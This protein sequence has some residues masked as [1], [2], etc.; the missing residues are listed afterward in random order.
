MGV[1][2]RDHDFDHPRREYCAEIAGRTLTNPQQA[3]MEHPL[4]ALVTLVGAVAV[5]VFLL[6]RCLG[7]DPR[8]NGHHSGTRLD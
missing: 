3:S 1:Q 4:L 2:E 5:F 8:E 6:Q 7:R